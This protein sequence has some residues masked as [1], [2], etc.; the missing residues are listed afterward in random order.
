MSANDREIINRLKNAFRKCVGVYS[1]EVLQDNMIAKVTGVS[2]S[3]LS[4]GLSN[5]GNFFDNP[6]ISNLHYG[7]KS[8]DE[9]CVKILAPVLIEILED[10]AEKIYT[11]RKQFL[12]GLSMSKV[13]AEPVIFF[14]STQSDLAGYLP[15]LF[16]SKSELRIVNLIVSND[17]TAHNIEVIEQWAYS[18]DGNYSD[19]LYLNVFERDYQPIAEMVGGFIEGEFR[20]YIYD[21]G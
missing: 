13:S 5:K 21:E 1:R 10:Q 6:R 7:L 17:A 9:K 18:S 20:A 3:T 2:P 16:Y 14:L 15:E 12:S 8:S 11:E 19:Q 4:D